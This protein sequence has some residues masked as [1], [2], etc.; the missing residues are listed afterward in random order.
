MP[1][2]NIDHESISISHHLFL[3][4]TSFTQHAF[5][6]CRRFQR[7]IVLIVD[8]SSSAR[9]WR[10]VELGTPSP[11]PVDN[12]GQVDLG[13][14]DGKISSTCGHRQVQGIAHQRRAA[15]RYFDASSL[16]VF[17]SM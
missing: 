9:M 4:F 7:R 17:E 10:S 12:L 15:T 5:F 2:Q 14:D 1:R 11:L 8:A 3:L 13:L 6:H 16:M